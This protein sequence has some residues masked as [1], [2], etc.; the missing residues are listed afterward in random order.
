MKERPRIVEGVTV[1]LKVGCGTMFVTVNFD[2]EKKPIEVFAYLGKSGSCFS[3]QVNSLCRTISIALRNDV[4][5]EEIIEHLKGM[6]CN[7]PSIHE[8]VQY[9]SCP[10]AIVKAIEEAMDRVQN[11]TAG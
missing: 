4:P 6:R 10:D 7:E 5:V 2:E 9:L 3:C 1:K 11:E 8:G